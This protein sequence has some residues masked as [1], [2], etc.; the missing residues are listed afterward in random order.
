MNKKTTNIKIVLY[1]PRIPQNTGCIARTTASL[2]VEL[3]LIQ[4]LGFSLES[5]YLKRAGLDYWPLVKL[6]VFENFYQYIESVR[7]NERI[8]GCSKKNGSNLFEFDFKNGDNLL[9][10][11]ED[12]GLPEDIRNLC[13]K[14]V[15]IPMP[16]I[17][18]QDGTGGVRSLNLSVAA[19]I[20]SFQA[21]YKLNLLTF[22]K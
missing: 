13:Y 15:S 18:N 12:I 6:T 17:S 10:G 19:G 7:P 14:I 2:K 22:K 1:E 16:G 8:I 5:K 21:A 20:I 3:I 11:R 9:F 4:P